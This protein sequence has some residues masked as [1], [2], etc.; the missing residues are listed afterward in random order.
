MRAG[1]KNTKKKTKENLPGGTEAFWRQG[2]HLL[3][4]GLQPDKGA[5]PTRS[6]ELP[7][8]NLGTFFFAL[9][10]PFRGYFC[11]LEVPFDLGAK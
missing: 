9:F 3:D 5:Y 2:N 10:A 7:C 11:F 6:P 1:A 8:T 4:I